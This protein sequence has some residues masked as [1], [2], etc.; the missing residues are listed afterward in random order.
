MDTALLVQTD[1][2]SLQ[3]L[4]FI[5]ERFSNKVVDKISADNP[6]FLM[7]SVPGLG[8]LVVLSVIAFIYVQT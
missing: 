5:V 4:L 3:Y 2:S 7:M 6:L 1:A 8:V